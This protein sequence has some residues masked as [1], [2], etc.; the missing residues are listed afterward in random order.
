LS[1]AETETEGTRTNQTI[2][3]EQ[4][5]SIDSTAV[6]QELSLS[7]RRNVTAHL[8]AFGTLICTDQRTEVGEI[9]GLFFLDAHRSQHETEPL[10]LIAVYKLIAE[11]LNSQ[12][13]MSHAT[14]RA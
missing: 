8:P 6:S 4:R 11:S 12:T 5:D 13:K 2:P 1:T 3:S 7:H 9:S 14:E 10:H